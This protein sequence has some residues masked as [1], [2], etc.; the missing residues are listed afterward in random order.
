[1]ANKKKAAINAGKMIPHNIEKSAIIIL[2]LHAHHDMLMK[3]K[4]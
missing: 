2:D 1:M 3:K 4:K